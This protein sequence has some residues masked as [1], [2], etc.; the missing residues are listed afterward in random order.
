LGG[1]RG[2][3]RWHDESSFFIRRDGVAACTIEATPGI[4]SG[5]DT[6]M[7][8]RM[9]PLVSIGIDVESGVLVMSG[10]V[11]PMAFSRDNLDD[12]PAT[13]IPISAL[14]H[15]QPPGSI[16]IMQRHAPAV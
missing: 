6:T 2:T 5:V 3:Y 4:A 11:Q 14:P 10:G 16:S 13:I 12:P 8:G 1:R 9:T 15:H 7:F